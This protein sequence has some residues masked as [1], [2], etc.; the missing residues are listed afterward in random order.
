MTERHIDEVVELYVLG[1]LE[2]PKQRAATQ[3]VTACSPCA[4]L[5]WAAEAVAHSQG[6]SWWNRL[7]VSR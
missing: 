3:H 5:V 1:V 4:H 2:A 6:T 7:T